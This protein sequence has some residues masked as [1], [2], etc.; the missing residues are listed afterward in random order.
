MTYG[1]FHLTIPAGSASFE[2]GKDVRFDPPAPIFKEGSVKSEP[3]AE[4]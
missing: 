2:G 4:P 3:V 1:R